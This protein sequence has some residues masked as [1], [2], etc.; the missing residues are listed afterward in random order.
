MNLMCF[1]TKPITRALAQIMFFQLR[2][3]NSVVVNDYQDLFSSFGNNNQSDEYILIEQVRRLFIQN[4]FKEGEG[5]AFKVTIFGS[6][7]NEVFGTKYFARPIDLFDSVKRNINSLYSEYSG[8]SF[9][10]AQIGITV[11][12]AN[13]KNAAA[14]KLEDFV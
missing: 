6:S 3:S 13:I 10:V 8:D 12:Q 4:G 14:S 7:D 11:L 5:V 1:C 2:L 9:D